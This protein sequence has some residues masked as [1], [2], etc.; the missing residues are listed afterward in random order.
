L[1]SIFK[2]GLAPGKQNDRS[3]F[4]FEMVSYTASKVVEIKRGKEIAEWSVEELVG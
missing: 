2:I 3:N 1:K 4:A